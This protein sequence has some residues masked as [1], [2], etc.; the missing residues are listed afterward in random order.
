MLALARGS[1]FQAGVRYQCNPK[2]TLRAKVNSA[3]VVTAAAMNKC[4]KGVAVTVTGA[5]SSSRV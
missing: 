4:C 1:S 3:G 2:T 5:V